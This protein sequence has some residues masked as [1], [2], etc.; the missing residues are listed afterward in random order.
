[1]QPSNLESLLQR[2][3]TNNTSHRHA[4]WQAAASQEPFW[5]MI[6]YDQHG[7]FVT[8]VN[9]KGKPIM[10]DENATSGEQLNA[11]RVLHNLQDSRAMQIDWS[12]HSSQ[13]YLQ[14]YPHLLYQLLRCDNL[15]DSKMRPITVATGTT[16]VLLLLAE[17]KDGYHASFAVMTADG[18]CALDRLVSDQYALCGTTIHPI[19][20]LGRDYALLTEFAITVQ[21]AQL[22]PYLTAL[23]STV[24]NIGLR[25]I[26]FTTEVSPHAITLQPTLI[27]ESVDSDMTLNMLLTSTTSDDDETMGALDLGIAVSVDL[28]HRHITVRRRERV[29]I[30][31]ETEFLM[32]LLRRCAPSKAEAR[33]LYC[34]PRPDSSIFC[35]PPGTALAFLTQGLPSIL[36]RYNLLGSDKLLDFKLKPVR[37]RLNVSLS[38]GIDFLEGS[39][40]VSLGDEEFSVYDLLAQFKKSHYITLTDGN[41]ALIDEKFMQRLERLFARAAKKDGKVKISFF[42]L[43][44]VEAMLGQKV[45]G[46]VAERTH[47]VFEGF[48]HLPEQRMKFGQVNATLRNYQKEGV[49]WLNYLYENHLGGCLADDMGLG[50]TLQTITMLARIYP[51]VKRP[52]LLVMPRSL[53]FNWENELQRFAPQL[54][55]TIYYGPQRDLTEALKSQLVLTTYA[56]VRNDIEQLLEHE[57]HYIILDES[58]NIK[59][60]ASQS[61]KAVTLLKAE[62]RLALSGTPIENN[63]VELYSLFRF[64][65]P[66]MFGSLQD[67]NNRFTTPI[68]RNDDQEAA[69][70]LRR[71][72]FP[73]ILR[74]LKRDVLTELPARTD[75]TLTV[76]MSDEH[77]HFYEQRR[78]FYE[79]M[80]DNTLKSEGVNAAQ[81]IMFQALT[82]LR[83]AASI[84]E[85]LTDGRVRS[86]K[87]DP[88]C[89][90]L[91]EAVGNGHKVVVFFNFIAGIEIVG[92]M[93]TEQGIDYAMMTG[94]TTDRRTVVERFQ[95]DPQCMVLL[96]T[97]K[98]G[99]VGLNLTAADT[100]YIFEPWWNKAAEEQAINRLHRIGQKAKVLSYSIVVHDTIEDKIRQ[101]QQQ[102]SDLAEAIISSDSAM[103]KQ[104][105]EEDIRFIL[106]K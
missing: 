57:F 18:P 1:M 49:K 35:I 94:S 30:A 34:D 45:L 39:A 3:K 55:F 44:E 104:L 78:R 47:S 6:S 105:T 103:S 26:P 8:T 60:V 14:Q 80:V 91:L 95:N 61:T 19:K 86:A 11:L 66:S 106:S 89:D 85:S 72:V 21:P 33:S 64:L 13:I 50:K 97:L 63:L 102:K 23:L 74:R 54:T 43:P 20:P 29:S 15:V 28:E 56:L 70:T 62:H 71:K 32:T 53:L 51:K 76:E 37:P 92:D 5:L 88:L 12:D 68:Q 2:L 59:N 36:G 16:Q 25:H 96:M 10:V 42:D 79:A 83:R 100:V 77:K 98:T 75:Q 41:R 48:N 90:S 82:E 24:D 4:H 9:A 7:A 58:Q 52:S 17:G 93:L 38:S 101:L 87:F 84:P 65:N 99:G 69:T 40:T 81:F 46:Q 27:F 31:A 22:R 67:F 73:F